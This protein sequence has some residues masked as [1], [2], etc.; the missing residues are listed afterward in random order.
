MGSSRNVDGTEEIAMAGILGIAAVG[1]F[2]FHLWGGG[3]LV[4][5]EKLDGS[6]QCTYVH[7]FGTH[8]TRPMWAAP[9]PKT[10]K[11]D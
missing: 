8:K 5:E 11:F 10:I 9:C 2:V 1:W 3:I 7:S 6:R 4:Y